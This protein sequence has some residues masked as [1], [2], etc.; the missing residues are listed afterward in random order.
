MA[1]AYMRE[2]RPARTKQRK[3]S[4][5]L[6]QAPDALLKAAQPNRGPMDASTIVL[7]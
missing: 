2:R 6:Q 4:G 7:S 5:F 3:M 1:K